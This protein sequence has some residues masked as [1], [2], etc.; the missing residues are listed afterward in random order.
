MKLHSPEYLA[1][2]NFLANAF[3]LIWPYPVP[4]ERG[5]ISALDRAEKEMPSRA[6]EG[7]RMAVDDILER[8]IRLP[9]ETLLQYDQ[10][11]EAKHCLTFS[12]ARAKYWKR[13][14]RLLKSN[15]KLSEVDYYLLKSLYD[16]PDGVFNEDEI[17][18]VA[19]LLMEFEERGRE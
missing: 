5:P 19:K 10:I 7:L 4:A 15:K 16:G 17:Q 8:S 18:H 13:V 14:V 12:A 2:K 6:V 11:L 3:P 9:R 1:L